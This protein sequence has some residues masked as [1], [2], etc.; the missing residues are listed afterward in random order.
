[1]RIWSSRGVASMHKRD[2]RTINVATIS[3]D[4]RLSV[5]NLAAS[6][7]ATECCAL[8]EGALQCPGDSRHV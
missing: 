6:E 5:I 4:V 2:C 8:H 7:Q 3:A 1:M